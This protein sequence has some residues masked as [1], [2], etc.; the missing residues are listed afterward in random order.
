MSSLG[1]RR[2]RS[3]EPI[4]I[5]LGRNV[6]WM[7]LLPVYGF[8]LL[9]LSTQ[10]KFRGPKVS[11]RMFLFLIFFSFLKLLGQ[12]S[13]LFWNYLANLLFF[14][15]TTWPIFFSFLKL[16]GQ[17][18]PNYLWMLIG[19]S[20]KKFMFFLLKVIKRNKRPKGVKKVVLWNRWVYWNP[21]WYNVGMS[22]RNYTLCLYWL[23]L[24]TQKKQEAQ[25][26]Q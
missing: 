23:E 2:R 8:A 1:F 4:G 22:S 12:S 21:T 26:C 15:E 18:E 13:F 3:P 24:F 25:R 5:K 10:K 7:V 17:L 11:I 20:S 6:H 14:S 9:I 19:W 16:L